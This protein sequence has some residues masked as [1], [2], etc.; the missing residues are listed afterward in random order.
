[1]LKGPLVAEENSWST[2][3]QVS[4]A[5]FLINHVQ[6]ITT[7]YYSVS[8]K[9]VFLCNHKNGWSC[10]LYEWRQK[11]GRWWYRG[12]SLILIPFQFLLVPV[13]SNSVLIPSPQFL[14]FW[15]QQIHKHISALRAS[16]HHLPCSAAQQSHSAGSAERKTP[17]AAIPVPNPPHQE[18]LIQWIWF[19]VQSGQPWPA[20]EHL[21][22]L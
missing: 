10:V 6:C 17:A 4:W 13:Y 11:V 2:N 16:L 15:P 18:T 20:D 1:M 7:V 9:T 3:Q 14:F 12:V 19:S 22:W 8:R 5:V 21:L